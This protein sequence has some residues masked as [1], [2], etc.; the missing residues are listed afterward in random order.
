MIGSRTT[1]KLILLVDPDPHLR[2]SLRGPLE[3]A[4]FSVGEACSGQEGERT[5]KRVHVDAVIVDVLLDSLVPGGSVAEKLR[6]TGSR[7]PVY[8]FTEQSIATREDIDLEALNIAGVFTKPFDT[9][10]IIH[11]L[12]TRLKVV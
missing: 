7:I 9:A 1:R 3:N 10:A 12:K 6:A 4:G 2:A 8:V 11:A 5:I